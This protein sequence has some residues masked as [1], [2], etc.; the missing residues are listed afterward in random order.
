MT[1]ERRRNERIQ[2]IG[3][4]PGEVTLLQPVRVR[5]ASID[6]I[7][8]DFFQPLRLNSIHLLRLDL[9]DRSVVLKGRVV[10]CRVTSVD[11]E[12]LTYTAGVQFVE[13]PEH[14]KAALEQFV[15][16]ASNQL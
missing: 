5:E 2:I 16:G 15:A 11:G 10:H 8:A 14:A 13:V 1:E 7:R 12:H 3:S 9:G 4:L 6:G